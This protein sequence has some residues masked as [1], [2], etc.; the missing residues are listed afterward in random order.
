MVLLL[1]SRDLDPR[2]SSKSYHFEMSVVHQME[3]LILFFIFKFS[4][5][6]RGGGKKQAGKGKK[7]G[8]TKKESYDLIVN[9]DLEAWKLSAEQEHSTPQE[10]I[11]VIIPS[12]TRWQ[13]SKRSSCSSTETKTECCPSRSCSLS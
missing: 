5:V 1:S 9:I 8:K 12:V 6:S 13:S 3:I 11:Y 7:S 10:N 2:P 4:N